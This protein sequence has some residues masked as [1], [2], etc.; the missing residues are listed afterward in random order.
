VL[1]IATAGPGWTCLAAPCVRSPRDRAVRG[2]AV[3]TMVGMASA[4]RRSDGRAPDPTPAPD[5]SATGALS[6]H[7]RWWLRDTQT[8][9]AAAL[10]FAAVVALVWANVSPHSYE[11]AWGT[12][13]QIELG[14]YGIALTL[15]EWVNSGLMTFFFL[16]VGLETRREFDLGEL[17]E[18]RRVLIPV[19]A[20]LGAIVVPVAIFI[21]FNAGHGTA[22]AW[23]V[24]MSTDTALALGILAL[25]GRRLPSGVRVV[26]LTVSV[27]DDLVALAVIATAYSGSVNMGPLF[28]GLGIFSLVFVAR[29]LKI[30]AGL[31]YFVLG[32]ACW[33]AVQ[34]SG[35]DPIVVGLAFGLC[36]YAHPASRA[37][38][39]QASD[40]FRQFREQPTPQFARSARHGVARALSP[41]DRLSGLYQPWTVF[42]I[43]PIFALA[44]AG[45]SV[46]DGALGRAFTSPV[47]LGVLIGLVVGKPVGF[48]AG[49]WLLDRVTRGRLTPPVGWAGS[50]AGGAV[51]AVGFTVSLL[52]AATALTGEAREAAVIGVLASIPGSAVLTWLISWVTGRLPKS[53]RIRAL[54]GQANVITD[55]AVP[56]DPQRD[57]IRGPLDAPV[58]VVEYGDFECP[59]C[60]QAEPVVRELLADFGDVRYVWRHL[61]LTDV[62]PHA[63]LAAQA[64]E[65]AAAQG[66]FWEMH[67]LLFR[68]QDALELDDLVGYAEQLGLDADR[69]RADV[70]DGVYADRV[71]T[72]LESADLSS[73]SGTPTFFINDRRHY[74]AYDIDA[75]KSAVRTA[76]AQVEPPRK[77]EERP[78]HQR[79]GRERPVSR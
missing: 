69:F 60:G 43:L 61:P 76:R 78:R 22:H 27:V 16:V 66:A 35:V 18:R 72:D 12:E 47:G 6:R 62:H 45:V 3:D 75:L 46:T 55:L 5:S 17:R 73:V 71:G 53:L 70:H 37:Y 48:L 28:V 23:G 74:G 26:V 33:L 56:V 64:A 19:M 7:R 8:V 67:D 40:L 39:E 1:T 65:A 9:G 24:A 10:L 11:A 13:L 49:A 15:H 32:V 79:G 52:I 50:A 4:T 29:A 68:H 57:H 36:V 77:T 51:S 20:A 63:F 21:V 54:Y 58:T 30:R 38:L 14:A 41:N 31:V 2:R 44:N 42:V 25:V 34:A 59:Y